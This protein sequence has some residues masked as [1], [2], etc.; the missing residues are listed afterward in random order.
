MP[1]PP[2]KTKY[3]C[4]P[5]SYFISV[6]FVGGERRT[7]AARA[8]RVHNRAMR[9][10]RLTG[11]QIQPSLRLVA[12]SE[13]REGSGSSGTLESLASGDE[14]PPWRKKRARRPLPEVGDEL[15]AVSVG[16]AA[17]EVEE[18]DL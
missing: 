8:Q 15:L 5:Q 16:P 6:W 17:V 2:I 10:Q 12:R 4:Q 7:A 14:R 1:L 18:E 9:Q 13:R 11:R 3:A